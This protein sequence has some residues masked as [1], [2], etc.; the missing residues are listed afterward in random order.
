MPSDANGCASE[1]PLTITLGTVPNVGPSISCPSDI[2]VN[3]DLNACG[4]VVTY[5]PPVGTDACPGATTIRTAGPASGS[6]FPVGTTVITHRVT[7]ALG[8][9]AEC[10]FNVTVEDNELPTI[11]CPNNIVTTNTPG[12]CGA[13]VSY[14]DPAVGDNCAYTWSQTNGLE[15]G[16]VFPIGTTVNQFT[17]TDAS[18]NTATCSFSVTVTDNE[19]PTISN[20][21]A[22]VVMCNPVTWIPPTIT[23]NC[24]G[25]QITT[26]H[27]PNTQFPDG[28]V[29]VTTSR[30]ER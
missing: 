22:D 4:A 24:P 15:S 30:T 5:T 12:L 26:T 27:E 3:T 19:N 17:I 21:P 2:V 7:D 25:V 1:V 20:A 29:P 13:I 6:F 9:T 11:V 14:N 8:L 16:S 23:D 28:L 18:G 10:S